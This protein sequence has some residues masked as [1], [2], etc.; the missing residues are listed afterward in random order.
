ML[1]D[2]EEND[3]Q[4]MSELARTHL[5][6]GLQDPSPKLRKAIVSY[7]DDKDR[8]ERDP[9]KRFFQ[10]LTDLYVPQAEQAYLQF[11]SNMLLILTKESPDY[12]REL[13]ANPLSSSTWHEYPINA[14]WQQR[15][16]HMTPLF[17]ATQQS[18]SQSQLAPGEDDGDEQSGV[19]ATQATLAFTPTVGTLG[20]TLS[21]V[22]G[23]GFMSTFE[24]GG[25]SGQ[26]LTHT[27]Y[28]ATQQVLLFEGRRLRRA[29]AA[30]AGGGGARDSGNATVDPSLAT[31]QR[32]AEKQRRE[33]REIQRL[34]R[35][36]VK[37][38]DKHARAAIF[39]AKRAAAR[40][41]EARR[42]IEQRRRARSA[43]VNLFR[44]YRTGEVRSSAVVP[45]VFVVCVCV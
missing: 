12:G 4:A 16:I 3:L 33:A 41:E 35:R 6:L 7:W 34:R 13:F 9:I 14:A 38:N 25:I 11:V 18:S 32:A 8:L 26:T 31:A 30:A 20:D 28:T 5:L 27:Q 44:S 22:P 29:A 37:A 15:N 36:F 24:P 42:L 40:K 17:A 39:H 19:R 45:F 10:G 43:Q 1:S 23:A 21:G 2:A